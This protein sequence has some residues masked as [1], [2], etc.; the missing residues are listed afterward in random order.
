MGEQGGGGG[1][2]IQG[3]KCIFQHLLVLLQSFAPFFLPHPGYFS[4]PVKLSHHHPLHIHLHS[5]LI[6]SCSRLPLQLAIHLGGGT[7]TAP[8]LSHCTE[9]RCMRMPQVA[10]CGKK[11]AQ[12]CT[13]ETQTLACL[14][15]LPLVSGVTVLVLWRRENWLSL[16]SQRDLK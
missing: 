5:S 12:S 4:A 7:E 15:Y 13:A 3:R 11:G 1:G 9:Q 16:L 10:V 14:F 6:V 2:I 8:D